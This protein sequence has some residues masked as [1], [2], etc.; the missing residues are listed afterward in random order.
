MC[1]REAYLYRMAILCRGV[2]QVELKDLLCSTNL[3]FSVLRL[4][5]RCSE[6]TESCLVFKDC[7]TCRMDWHWN[8]HQVEN[9]IEWV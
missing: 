9:S 5:F 2:E 6:K 3:W 1:T 7:Q 8:L 4:L